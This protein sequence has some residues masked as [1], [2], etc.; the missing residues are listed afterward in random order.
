V[1]LGV[2]LAAR[3]NF[4]LLLPLVTA[5]ACR[6]WGARRGV[7]LLAFSLGCLAAV[8]LPFYLAD[9]GGF[10][11]T[12]QARVVGRHARFLPHAGLVVPAVALLAALALARRAAATGVSGL[13]GACAVVQAIPVAG[14]VIL[15]SLDAGRLDLTSVDY[16][17]FSLPFGALTAWPGFLAARA[18]RA[19]T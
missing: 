9:P 13:L 19:G 12:A 17:V 2:G 15:A 4:A 16:G 7:A 10:P 3:L 1:L 6:R 5:A 8:S 11:L 14:L 18:S